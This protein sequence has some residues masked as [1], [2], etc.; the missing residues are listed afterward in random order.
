MAPVKISVEGGDPESASLVIVLLHGAGAP[1]LDFLAISQEFPAG[2]DLCWLAPQ[3]L[4]RLWYPRP[5]H[6]SRSHQ[7]PYLTVSAKSV[8]GLLENHV[9]QRLVLMGFADGA[10]VV[11]ELLADSDLP[12]S[13]VGA[14]MAS[15]GL[16]GPEEE[17]P[18]TPRLA[19]LPV[20]ISGG[21][22]LADLGADCLTDTA[23]YF[24]RAGARV[25]RC[26][27]DGSEPGINAEEMAQAQSLLKEVRKR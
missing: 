6:T 14:W 19:S 13:V 20:L 5:T 23:R 1:A 4:N 12:S 24:E 8:L 3:A 26:L 15:G 21:R 2:D 25:T 7:Q 22:E 9:S 17:W 10:G 11:A 16:V 18:E 27:Y